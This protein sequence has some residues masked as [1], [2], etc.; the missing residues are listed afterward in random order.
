MDLPSDVTPRVEEDFTRLA[1]YARELNA[2]MIAIQEVDGLTAATKIFP[3]DQYSIHMTHD[4]VVQR[5]G[6]VVR[7]GMHYDINPDIVC[8]CRQTIC[9]V[10]PT[11]PSI[12]GRP[13]F[14]SWPST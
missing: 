6:I 7:R 14:A 2:D 12:L 8:A 11:S 13:T 10:A 4:H 3:R 5:V 9:A 1:Q